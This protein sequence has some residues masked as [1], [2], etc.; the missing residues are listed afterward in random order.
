MIGDSSVVYF[1]QDK[2]EWSCVIE[3]LGPTTINKWK[4]FRSIKNPVILK[5]KL[6]EIKNVSQLCQ[7]S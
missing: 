1:V 7:L 6:S 5:M 4:H 3:V 2:I